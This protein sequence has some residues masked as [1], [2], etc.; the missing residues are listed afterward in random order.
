MR[1]PLTLSLPA[2]PT[3]RSADAGGGAECF[4]EVLRSR[5]PSAPNNNIFEMTPR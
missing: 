2:L 3:S 4:D 5:A 1:V